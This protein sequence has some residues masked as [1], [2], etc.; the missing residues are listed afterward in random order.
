MNLKIKN[1]D[2]AEAFVGVATKPKEHLVAF[3]FDPDGFIKEITLSNSWKQF[4]F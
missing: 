1:S 3:A 2:L 4:K